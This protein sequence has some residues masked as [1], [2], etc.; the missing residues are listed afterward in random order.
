MTYDATT[1]AEARQRYEDGATYRELAEQLGA[2]PVTAR[3]LVARAGGSAR[4]RGRPALDLAGVRRLAGAV[5]SGRLT[6]T[7]LAQRL[8]CTRATA[9]K[10]L[11][12]VG[13]IR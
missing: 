11:R 9:R 5:E 6:V 12:R 3:R 2:S 8:D 1:A 4:R 13:V 7:A 10:A